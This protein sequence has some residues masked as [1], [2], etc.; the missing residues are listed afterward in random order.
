MTLLR[1]TLS[2]QADLLEIDS[3]AT[4]K[5]ALDTAAAA[6]SE[7]G[8]VAELTSETVRPVKKRKPKAEVTPIK[9]GPRAV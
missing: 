1:F 7:A 3:L 2:V 5:K 4:A 6:I 9:P 8:L